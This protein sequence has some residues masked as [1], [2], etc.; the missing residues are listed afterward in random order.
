MVVLDFRN[1]LWSRR[2]TA[3]KWGDSEL[4]KPEFFRTEA[5]LSPIPIHH[6]THPLSSS[7][8]TFNRRFRIMA[9][10]VGELYC[11]PAEE[12]TLVRVPDTGRLVVCFNTSFSLF[13]C[14]HCG[15][16]LSP[17]TSY[18]RNDYHHIWRHFYRGHR[19]LSASI[20]PQPFTA[21]VKSFYDQHRSLDGLAQLERFK[22]Q[23]SVSLDVA[24]TPIEGLMT[25]CDGFQCVVDGCRACFSKADALRSHRRQC[26][27]TPVAAHQSILS[28]GTCQ[29]VQQWTN[30]KFF[31]VKL[32][33]NE[34]T[35][36]IANANQ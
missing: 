34:P 32:D 18:E 12:T 28:I 31:P 29:S 27:H 33:S 22:N 4:H 35:D 8:D 15:L 21:A 30:Q 1:S 20:K 26:H 3:S 23:I 9:A 13:I 25:F 2:A 36:P 7:S 11:L 24:Y 19:P 14:G 17:L 6:L 16:P 10:P 5:D